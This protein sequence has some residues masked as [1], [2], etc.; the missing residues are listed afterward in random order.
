MTLS[1]MKDLKEVAKS[2]LGFVLKLKS[3]S[4]FPYNMLIVSL[5]SL[6][7]PCFLVNVATYMYISAKLK[8]SLK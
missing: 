8:Q 5:L 2:G 4:A 6:N 1:R 3:L 7:H